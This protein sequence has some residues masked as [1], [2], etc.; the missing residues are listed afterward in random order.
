M[1]LEEQQTQQKTTNEGEWDN[2][3]NRKFLKRVS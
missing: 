3:H 2:Q 1:K